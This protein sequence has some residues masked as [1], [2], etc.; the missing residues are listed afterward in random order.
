[1]DM[2]EAAEEGEVD[3]VVRL[4]KQG[5]DVNTEDIEGRTAVHWAA[6]GNHSEVLEALVQHRPNRAKLNGRDG[7]GMAPLHYTVDGEDAHLDAMQVLIDY[8]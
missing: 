4:L 7:C 6:V 8:Y 1:M 2:L 3:K 5:Q